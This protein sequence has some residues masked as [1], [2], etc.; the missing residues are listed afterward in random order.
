[1]SYAYNPTVDISYPPNFP[2]SLPQIDSRAEPRMSEPRMSE[3]GMNPH[4]THA[5]NPHAMNPHAMNPH[6]THAMNPHAMNPR[7]DYREPL[8][9]Y[10][11]PSMK[12]PDMKIKWIVVVKKVVIYTILFLLMSHIKVNNLL[13]SIIPYLTDNEV[14]CMIL[15]GIIFGIIIVLIQVIL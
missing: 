4:S 12:E 11:M 9:N 14:Q 8:I 1:M 3:H 10:A 6:S 13:C 7:T 5:M 15:K 2:P